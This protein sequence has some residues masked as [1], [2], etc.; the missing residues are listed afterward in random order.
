MAPVSK[1][2]DCMESQPRWAVN[3]AASIQVVVEELGEMR[4]GTRKPATTMAVKM[5]KR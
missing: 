5:R 4:P 1:L 2:E 3:P